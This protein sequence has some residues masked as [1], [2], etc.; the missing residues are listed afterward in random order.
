LVDVTSVKVKPLEIIEK[1]FPKDKFQILGTHPMFGPQS[2]AS[3]I[4]KLTDGFDPIYFY[5]R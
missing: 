1:Y 3:G 5:S 4:K 2:G